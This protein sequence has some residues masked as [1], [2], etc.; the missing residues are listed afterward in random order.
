V[1]Y[2]PELCSLA[3]IADRNIRLF[4]VDAERKQVTL[5]NLIPVGTTAYA[6][7]KMV[8]TIIRNLISNAL[9]FTD[10]GGMIEIAS[11]RHNNSINVIV[12]D[13]GIGMDQESID[14]LFRIDVKYSKA[15]T[16]GEQGTGLGLLLCKELIDR[17]NGRI[18]VESHIGQ[19]SRF[20]ISLPCTPPI[21]STKTP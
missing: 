7:H 13:T 17:N 3:G 10:T 19:G 8:D 9:K 21:L 12:A 2:A 20:I 1:E 4:A 11:A 16:A 18:W 15:G 5:K 6:D 14:K